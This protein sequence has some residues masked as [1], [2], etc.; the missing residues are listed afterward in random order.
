MLL[1]LCSCTYCVICKI[2]LRGYAYVLGKRG[3]CTIGVFYKYIH[4]P[5]LCFSLPSY[6]KLVPAHY[7]AALLN[8][9][10]L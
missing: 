7:N 5:L 6:H 9:D 3:P 4:G 8:Q 2:L 10:L 1:Y